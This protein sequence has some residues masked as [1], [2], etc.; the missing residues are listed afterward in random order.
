MATYSIDEYI[1]SLYPTLDVAPDKD[2]YVDLATKQTSSSAF[3]ELYNYAVALRACHE[4]FISLKEGSETGLVTN[5]TE[6]RTSISFW[7]SL[8]KDSSSTLA[9]SMYG[10]RLR[11]LIKSLGLS[12]SV[13]DPDVF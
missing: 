4:Y 1:T 9:M 10:K 5:K 11:A 2:L 13:G 3:G 8:P 7:N 6:G 12:A